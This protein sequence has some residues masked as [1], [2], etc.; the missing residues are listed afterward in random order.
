MAS[1]IKDDG[2]QK[3]TRLNDEDEKATPVAAGLAIL[4]ELLEITGGSKYF[5]PLVRS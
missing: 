5:F 2:E 3:D 4:R 1:D